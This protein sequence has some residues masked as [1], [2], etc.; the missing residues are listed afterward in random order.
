MATAAILKNRQISAEV[1]DRSL[2]NLALWHTFV[3]LDPS[4]P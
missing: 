3:P 2:L 1:F 4:D